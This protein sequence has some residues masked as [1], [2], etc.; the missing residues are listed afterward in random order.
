M[1]D[2]TWARVVNLVYDVLNEYDI[3]TW[4]YIDHCDLAFR[5]VELVQQYSGDEEAIKEG[6]SRYLKGESK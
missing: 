6:L 2:E 4:E 3:E 5:W 1:T